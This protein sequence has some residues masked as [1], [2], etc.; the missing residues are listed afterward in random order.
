MTDELRLY[1]PIGKEF[2]SH[3][4]VKH[5]AKEYVRGNV[6]TNTIEDFFSIFKRGMVGTFHHVGRQHLR[7]YTK[8]FDFRDNTRSARGFTDTD[9]ATLALKGIEGKRLLCKGLNF[10]RT[11]YV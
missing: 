6:H 5:S 4:T 2:A 3:E 1:K 8:E 9:R 10:Q 7:R 11:A